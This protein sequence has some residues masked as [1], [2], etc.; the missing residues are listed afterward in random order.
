VFE[1]GDPELISHIGSGSLLIILVD[2]VV[3]LLGKYARLHYTLLHHAEK[4]AA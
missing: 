3:R 2:C 4:I 1:D